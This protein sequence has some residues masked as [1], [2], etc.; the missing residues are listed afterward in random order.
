MSNLAL[1][2]DSAPLWWSVLNLPTEQFER[3]KYA[4]NQN[5]DSKGRFR[6]KDP[7]V[8]Q[9]LAP[10]LYQALADEVKQDNEIMMET[11]EKSIRKG[12]L[13]RK[14]GSIPLMAYH[15][16]PELADDAKARER[17]W[18]DNPWLRAPK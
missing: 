3:S 7:T 9:K 14:I 8:L 10:G 17:F 6:L 1:E 11:K 15:L 13:G 12:R 16:N 4:G 5:P 18:Q 2:P